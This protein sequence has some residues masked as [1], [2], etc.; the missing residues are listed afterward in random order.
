MVMDI[1]GDPVRISYETRWAIE[2]LGGDVDELF[3]RTMAQKAK[4]RRIGSMR[5]YM[6]QIAKNDLK[7]RT[8]VEL[9]VAQ[10]IMTGNKWARQAA[11]VKAS[12]G[13][14]ATPISTAE[15]DGR[16]RASA[17]HTDGA[18]LLAALKGRAS[19]GRGERGAGAEC[20]HDNVPLAPV[21]ADPAAPSPPPKLSAPASEALRMLLDADPNAILNETLR[22]DALGLGQFLAGVSDAEVALQ[23]MVARLQHGTVVRKSRSSITSWEQFRD[24]INDWLAYLA[25]KVK[26]S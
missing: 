24:P 10:D 1:E 9:G 4:G 8:G 6:V 26:A 16:R 19:P 12:G 5:R 18:A 14:A 23:V 11:I 3:D 13:I 7:E 15:E 2:A 21:V 25:R 20:Q 22:A 17:S